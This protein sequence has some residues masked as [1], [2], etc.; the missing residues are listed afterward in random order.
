MSV[1]VTKV[2]G[3]RQ[4][5]NRKKVVNTCLRMGASRKIAEMIASE[6]EETL[7]DGIATEQIF[8]KT[9]RLLRKH[10]P[11]IQHLL[12]LRKGLSLMNSK[13]EFELF[14]QA[15]LRENGYEVT[16]NRIIRGKCGE[17]EVDAIAKKNGITYVVEAKHHIKYHTP[18]GLDESRIARAI[19]ED[20][21]EG[22]VFGQNTLKI[23]QAMI[24]TNTK[25]SKHARQYGE[26]RKILQIGWNLPRTNS[27]QDMIEKNKMHPL[28]CLRKLNTQIKRKLSSEGIILMKQ[29]IEEEPSKLAHRIGI[30]TKEVTNI[31]KKATTCFYTLHHP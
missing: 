19:L 25:F 4:L 3:S 17:H 8:Q 28:T 9:L 15:L 27:L 5:F 1:F 12:D 7:Y 18:T 30:S 26:C 10:E 13:P 16:P 31:I 14:I 24:I 11:I 20:V 21:T 2:D 22:A 23:D 6:V 29:L